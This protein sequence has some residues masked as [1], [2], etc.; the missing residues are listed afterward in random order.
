MPAQVIDNVGCVQRTT[1]KPVGDLHCDGTGELV[2][3]GSSSGDSSFSCPSSDI[4]F[5]IE[6]SGVVWSS[7]INGIYK[8]TIVGDDVWWIHLDE[9][10]LYINHDGYLGQ[11]GWVINR[12]IPSAEKSY[13][14]PDVDPEDKCLPPLDNWIVA[15][16]PEILG[17]PTLTEVPCPSSAPSSGDSSGIS[18]GVSS[19]DI[20][21][22]PS[23]EGPSSDVSSEEISSEAISSEG[24]SS[25]EIPESSSGAESSEDSSFFSSE[26]LSSLA[27]S[28][29]FSSEDLSSQEASSE[30]ESRLF[31]SERA[32]SSLFASEEVCPSLASTCPDCFNE[33]DGTPNWGDGVCHLLTDGC[34]AD[35]TCELNE[36]DVYIDVSGVAPC[37]PF[38][39]PD[40]PAADALIIAH[41]KSLDWCACHDLLEC[42]EADEFFDC[43]C[44]TVA[45]IDIH[46]C[47][48]PEP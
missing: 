4:E 10:T 30:G 47:C 15:E 34:E 8:G 39:H 9:P 17:V 41:M 7:D 42:H 35:T 24:I 21:S 33:G 2:C 20:S 23:S 1:G 37:L 32:V 29:G 36:F 6:V 45:I 31:S 22:G 43:A 5:C 44:S 26:D 19:E 16:A 13:W 12:E 28:S 14:R 11:P 25:L 18:S 27:L 38:G 40:Q 48:Y 46:R 3:G